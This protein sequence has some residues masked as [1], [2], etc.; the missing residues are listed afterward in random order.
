MNL[1]VWR[2]FICFDAGAQRSQRFSAPGCNTA[3]ART[4]AAA[5][6]AEAPRAVA[7]LGGGTVGD[8]ARTRMRGGVDGFAVVIPVGLV[9]IEV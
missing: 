9:V 8:F 5:M 4:G 3:V 2:A 7:A 6:P 1:A